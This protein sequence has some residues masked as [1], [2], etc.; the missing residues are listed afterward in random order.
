MMRPL[1]N[2]DRFCEL[3]R[4]A[5]WS[6][7]KM[8]TFYDATTTAELKSTW[9]HCHTH[10]TNPSFS[11]APHSRNSILQMLSRHRKEMLECT[12]HSRSLMNLS[13]I[14]VL[15]KSGEVHRK[16]E[17]HKVKNSKL[18]RRLETE[19][20]LI[21]PEVKASRSA[22]ISEQPEKILTSFSMAFQKL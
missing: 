8:R 9:R 15:K 4:V 12:D 16:R 11:E 17:Q 6:P 20:P 1:H 2:I 13:F 10:T 5:R 19:L 7:E 21:T 18:Q 22:L 14:N 3:K